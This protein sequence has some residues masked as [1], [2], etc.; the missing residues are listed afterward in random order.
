MATLDELITMNNSLFDLLIAAKGTRAHPHIAKAWQLIY[1]DLSK[2][3]RAEKKTQ[4]KT[5][6]DPLAGT[7]T[8]FTIYEQMAE[9]TKV[10]TPDIEPVPEEVT[11]GTTPRRGLKPV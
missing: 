2:A 5:A 9:Q 3:E 6:P 11:K 10:E 4:K 1:Q 8:Q 7:V